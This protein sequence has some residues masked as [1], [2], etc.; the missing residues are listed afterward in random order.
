MDDY[1]T[2]TTDKFDPDEHIVRISDEVKAFGHKDDIEIPDD[3]VDQDV[4]ATS[5]WRVTNGIEC[6][7]PMAAAGVDT[8]KALGEP[9]QLYDTHVDKLLDGKHQAA[10]VVTEALARQ[11]WLDVIDSLDQGTRDH[12]FAMKVARRLGWVE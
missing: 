2:T 3:P 5:S 9:E 10:R 7:C 1:T 8:D 11:A 6:Y 12:E 4:F